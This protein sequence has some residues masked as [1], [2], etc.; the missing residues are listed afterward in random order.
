MSKESLQIAFP[1][2]PNTH[3]VK[4]HH[5]VNPHI[6]PI[7]YLVLAFLGIFMNFKKS[8]LVIAVVAFA[9]LGVG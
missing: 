5:L 2:P 8:L 9:T 6:L 4:T 1:S 7:F 3:I